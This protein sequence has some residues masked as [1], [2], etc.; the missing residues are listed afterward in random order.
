MRGMGGPMG[1]G[2]NEQRDQGSRQAFA[3]LSERT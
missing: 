1:P 2:V 3:S